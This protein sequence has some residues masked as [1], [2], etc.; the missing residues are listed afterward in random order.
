VIE[1]KRINGEAGYG[2]ELPCE[3]KFRGIFLQLQLKKDKAV[4]GD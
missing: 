2:M 3:F 4:L 1:G